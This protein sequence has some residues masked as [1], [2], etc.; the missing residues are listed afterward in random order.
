MGGGGAGANRN[1][2]KNPGIDFY[3]GFRKN[4]QGGGGVQ[5]EMLLECRDSFN[6]SGFGKTLKGG[7]GGCN[8][9]S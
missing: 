9:K 4:D 6:N 5:I 7:G 3:S 2:K 1:P 8:L